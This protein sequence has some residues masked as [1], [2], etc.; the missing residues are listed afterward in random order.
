MTEA[1]E[2]ILE[3]LE[4]YNRV[5]GMLVGVFIVSVTALG[6]VANHFIQATF[7]SKLLT[8]PA[9]VAANLAGIYW[10][11]TGFKTDYTIDKIVARNTRL[12]RN[13]I[14]A[15]G[16]LAGVLFFWVFM[17]TVTNDIAFL[18]I[19]MLITSPMLFFGYYG[20]FPDKM[21]PIDRKLKELQEEK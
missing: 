21:N 9:V 10:I 3:G 7:I 13:Q 4:A 5:Y 11:L 18:I 16:M 12:T 14:Q 20:L 2:E 8:N 6:L 19:I 1:E 17:I 15:S